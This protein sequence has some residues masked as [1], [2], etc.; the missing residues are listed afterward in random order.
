MFTQKDL[1]DLLAS[2]QSQ[3]E[4][5]KNFVDALN[6]AKAQYEEELK[7]EEEAK[8]AEAEKLE[9]LAQCIARYNAFL[10]RWYPHL[11]EDRDLTEEEV[12]DLATGMLPVLDGMRLTIRNMSDSNSLYDLFRNFLF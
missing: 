9:E 7:R 4:L 1:Y 6:A 3:E 10:K 12:H 2:G 5:A 8:A 11:T